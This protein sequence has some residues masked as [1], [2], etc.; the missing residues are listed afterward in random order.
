MPVSLD[1]PSATPLLLTPSAP[2]TDHTAAVLAAAMEPVPAAAAAAAP[3]PAPTVSLGPAAAVEFIPLIGD[4]E[5]PRFR[6]IPVH[7]MHSVH[8][9]QQQQQQQQQGPDLDTA[10]D[11]QQQQQQHLLLQQGEDEGVA[12]VGEALAD[13]LEHRLSSHALDHISP[14]TTAT[15]LASFAQFD[16]GGEEFLT[17]SSG[18]DVGVGPVRR[19]ED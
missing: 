7:D 19:R 4:L 16:D 14:T 6:Q 2:S 17:G 10:Y 5:P 18:V 9:Q 12:G 1:V 13:L 15:T 8:Q 3:A 11:Q